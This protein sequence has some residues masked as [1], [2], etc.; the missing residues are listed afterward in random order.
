MPRAINA[1]EE[2]VAAATSLTSIRMERFIEN[3]WV[4]GD[5]PWTRTDP[6]D[7]SVISQETGVRHCGT[8]P[9]RRLPAYRRLAEQMDNAT[10]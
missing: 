2:K 4:D 1:A 3:P 7:H 6:K 5:Y 8:H 9:E 10:P